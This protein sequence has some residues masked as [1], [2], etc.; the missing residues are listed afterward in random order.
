MNLRARVPERPVLPRPIDAIA[1]GTLALNN[2]IQKTGSSQI[3]Q[4]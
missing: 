1:D 4:E 2:K 3:V